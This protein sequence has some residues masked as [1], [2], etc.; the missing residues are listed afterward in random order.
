MNS[1]TAFYVAQGISI[2]TAILS[3][4]LMQLKSM[5]KILVF[6]IIVNTTTLLNYFLLGG[7]TGVL[8]SVLAIIQSVVMFAYNRR[9]LKP[10]MAVIVAFVLAYAGCSAYNIS[11]TGE[12]I[13]L[14]PALAAICF[15]V[16]LVQQNPFAFRVCYLLNPL[17]W[18]GYDL[19]TR[20]Y[21]L[22][23]V[24]I[25]ILISVVVAMIR[26]DDI[27]KLK[28]RHDNTTK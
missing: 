20:S 22:F 8:V 17:L 7:D 16:S 3:V 10:H 14:L 4:I 19:Y 18:A 6:Q 1:Q 24:H 5:R 28:K 9:D 23:F 27:L 26:V 12:L 13:E 2:I 25:G 15:S 11:V 21:V